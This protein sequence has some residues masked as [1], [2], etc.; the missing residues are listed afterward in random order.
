MRKF[1]CL[2][3]SLILCVLG[4]NVLV[5]AEA[6]GGELLKS[7]YERMQNKEKISLTKRS[8]EQKAVK[9]Y[10]KIQKKINETDGKMKCYGGCYINDNND[11]VVMTD[12]KKK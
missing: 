2:I 10:H 8:E 4:Q 9:K 12:N 1:I 11:V 3:L 7:Y 5:K 6:S